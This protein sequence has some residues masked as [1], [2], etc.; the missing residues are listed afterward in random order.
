MPNNGWIEE[1][2]NEQEIATA[3]KNG[4]KLSDEYVVCGVCSKCIEFWLLLPMFSLHHW[5]FYLIFFPFRWN[6]LDLIHRKFDIFPLLI[7]WKWFVA[8]KFV[9]RDIG[10]GWDIKADELTHAFELKAFVWRKAKM[11][12]FFFMYVGLLA[13]DGHKKGNSSTKEK[14]KR[15]RMEWKISDMANRIRKPKTN[16]ETKHSH[17]PIFNDEAFRV[18][19][20]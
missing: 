7:K 10:C 4:P 8:L 9:R 12:G 2:R 20:R 11:M 3:P 16:N 17:V 18:V 13:F 14:L 15:K 1:N 5:S 6:C 19:G